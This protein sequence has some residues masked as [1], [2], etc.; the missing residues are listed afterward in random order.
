MRAKLCQEIE[1]K[2]EQELL[3]KFANLR[4]NEMFDIFS[5]FPDSSP[6]LNDLKYALDK[7]NLH[8]LLANQMKHQFQ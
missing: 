6:C 8:N 3:S 1:E 5:E 7:T 4:T 2:L